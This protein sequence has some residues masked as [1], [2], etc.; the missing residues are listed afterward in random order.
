MKWKLCLSICL[1]FLLSAPLSGCR[2][3]RPLINGNAPDKTVGI[4]RIFKAEPGAPPPTGGWSLQSATTNP[5]GEEIPVFAAGDK[6]YIGMR[7]SSKI[8]TNITFSKFTYF[9]KETKEMNTE[10]EVGSSSDLMKVWGPGQVDLLAFDSPWPVPDDPGY[11]QLN[12]YLDSEI[13]AS[14]IFQVK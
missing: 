2:L 3:I 6:M 13:V 14:D 12:V 8:K 9:N 5:N 7:I 11:Y 4:I 10:V 1:I